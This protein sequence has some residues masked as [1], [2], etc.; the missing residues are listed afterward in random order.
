MI[1]VCFVIFREINPEHALF[2]FCQVVSDVVLLWL[3]VDSASYATQHRL[4]I[5]IHELPLYLFW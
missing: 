1:G 5:L 2:S 4:W 3:V